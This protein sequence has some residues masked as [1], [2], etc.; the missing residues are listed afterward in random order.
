MFQYSDKI[1][2]NGEAI[3]GLS[4]MLVLQLQKVIAH[5]SPEIL[6]Q[7]CVILV[8]AL[9]FGPVHRRDQRLVIMHTSAFVIVRLL[10]VA[11]I[12]LLVLYG[13]D[14]SPLTKRKY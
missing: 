11:V 10:L 5:A 3:A 4:N 12:V 2:M 1:F 8:E 7:Y 13:C 14:T 6:E 9:T